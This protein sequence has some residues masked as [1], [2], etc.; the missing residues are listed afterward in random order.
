M[1][2]R[3]GLRIAPPSVADL[4]AGVSVALVALPQALAYAELAGMPPVAGLWAI[5]PALL[6]AAP[7]L[8]AREVQ[9]GPVAT[10]SLLAF[11][12][13]SALAVP[14]GDRWM[15]LAA[16]LALLV[17]TIR[18]LIG[19]LGWG[20]IAYLL[21]RSVRLGFLN[22]AAVLIAASQLPSALGVPATGDVLGSAWRA[23]RSPQVWDPIAIGFA[24]GTIAIVHLA[25]RLHPLLPGVLIAV[26]AALI[27]SRLV[28]Y[29]GPVVGPITD[30]LPRMR[31]DLP[32]EAIPRLLVGALVLA[33]V[34]FSE[35]A[36]I[37]RDLASRARRP[38]SP[39]RE[40][41]AQGVA[42]LASGA[43]GGFPVGASFSRS[44]VAR[45]AGATSR[46]SGFVTGLALL[47]ALPFTPL[48]EPLPRAVL[49][50]V[51]LAALTSLIRPAELW[52][53]L[54]DSRSQGVIAIA[55]FVLTLALAPRIDEAVLIGVLLAI[56]QH[57]RREQH[58]RL[59][60]RRDN[61]TVRIAPIGV[62]WYGS[63]Q[64]F[65]EAIPALLSDHADVDTLVVDLS[66]CGLVDW[67]AARAIREGLDQALE[68]GLEVRIERVPVHARRWVGSVW[69]GITIGD[70]RRP[71]AP[72]GGDGSPPPS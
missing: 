14:G 56:G 2:E 43:F 64:R 66:G 70:A 32:W 35:A 41:V 18:V 45:M 60:V 47:A 40:F 63:A 55:T 9:V 25:R 61:G 51:I 54:R 16:V 36:S 17:G 69:Y 4:V 7:F 62:F 28:G 27:V 50:G 42:N 34:G 52:S 10:T 72:G 11:G 53:V 59:D 12:T 19:V 71:V 49:A 8:S 1:A 15:A 48:L 24:F 6:L 57:L 33:L 30:A 44:A 39:G 65:D 37:G 31:L 5:V 58:L 21:S 13:L 22:A 38:W 20:R 26:V 67:S 68:L 3:F 23:I 46:W 29:G